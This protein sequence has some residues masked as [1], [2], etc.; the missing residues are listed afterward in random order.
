[1][2]VGVKVWDWKCTKEP[3]SWKEGR[4]GRLESVKSDRD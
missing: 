1:M 4:R 2:G 3:E